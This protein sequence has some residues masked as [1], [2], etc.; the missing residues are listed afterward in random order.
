MQLRRDKK[1][2]NQQADYA[3]YDGGVGS[4]EPEALTGS[5]GDILDTLIASCL[6]HNKH[7]SS[8]QSRT[9]QIGHI[10]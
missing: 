3:G 5:E 9:S 8:D 7:Q 10:C 1:H 2:Y 4:D 6:Q